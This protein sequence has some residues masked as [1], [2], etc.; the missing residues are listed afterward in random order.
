M[1]ISISPRARPRAASK[2]SDTI[3][4]QMAG[5]VP[6]PASDTISHSASHAT[7]EEPTR[8]SASSARG[9]ATKLASAIGLAPQRSA[10]Q[11]TSGAERK[12]PICWKVA[13]PET[14]ARLQPYSA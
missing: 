10:S 13:A 2:R 9:V 4:A 5:V 7:T 11:P 6:A 3:R 14:E 1:P 12:M 8:D